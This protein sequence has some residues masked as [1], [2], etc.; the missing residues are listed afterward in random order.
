[1]I[2]NQSE[3]SSLS[4][5]EIHAGFVPLTACAPLVMAKELGI[6][7]RHGFSLVLHREASWA[8]IRDK[9]DGDILDCAIML[10]PMP[11]AAT[12]GLGGRVPVPMIAP[13]ATSLNG[14]AITV[15]RALFAEMVDVDDRNA[16]VGGMAAVQ[17]LAAVVERRRTHGCEPLTLGMVHPF[18]C[19]NYDLRYW[20]ASAG[21]NPD[22][23]ANLV[24]VPPPLIAGALKSGRIDGFCVG[25]RWSR[26]AVE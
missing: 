9:V 6:D 7:R 23:D 16:R 24:V 17:A 11:L 21:I 26:H 20:L 22:H 10:A 2:A 1:M 3:A 13:M 8:N 25:M 15:S 5:S 18:S 14:S 4:R 19:H 12:L